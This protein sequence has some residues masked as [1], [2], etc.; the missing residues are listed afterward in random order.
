MKIT[1]SQ[2]FSWYRL[3]GG[4]IP[5]ETCHATVVATTEGDTA[6]AATWATP[7]AAADDNAAAYNNVAAASCA[8]W[9]TP[10][11]VAAAYDDADAVAAYAADDVVANT[12]SVAAGEV[13]E[14]AAATRNDKKE[15][16]KIKYHTKMSFKK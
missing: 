10:A 2:L 9:A 12:A 14:V 3:K 11:D 7:A 5:F 4:I 16:I 13:Q 6:T 15:K 8:A 1:K